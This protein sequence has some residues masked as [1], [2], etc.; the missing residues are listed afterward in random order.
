LVPAR[1]ASPEAVGNAAPYPKFK[2]NWSR[3]LCTS[4]SSF[5]A[6]E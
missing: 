6:G 1:P 4:P 5:V 2:H 3:P